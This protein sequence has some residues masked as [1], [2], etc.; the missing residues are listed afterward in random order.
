MGPAALYPAA[1][2]NLFHGHLPD[3]AFQGVQ[4]DLANKTWPRRK[5][6]QHGSGLADCCCYT[7]GSVTLCAGCCSVRVLCSD[8]NP[9][10]EGVGLDCHAA[11]GFAGRL[12]HAGLVAAIM[13]AIN[14]SCGG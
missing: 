14:G 11:Q 10:S 9:G 12:G 7:A 6:P 13:A 4:T 3:L 1:R 8:S 5:G 2:A